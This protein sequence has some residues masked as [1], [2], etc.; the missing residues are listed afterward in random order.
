MTAFLVEDICHIIR[1]P[2]PF[3]MHHD[4]HYFQSNRIIARLQ[5]SLQDAANPQL[6]ASIASSQKVSPDIVRGINILQIRYTVNLWRGQWE[7]DQV[8]IPPSLQKQVAQQLMK[9]DFVEDQIASILYVSEYL[10]SLN[11]ITAPEVFAIFE[12]LFRSNYVTN[13]FV[14]D[15]FAS[16]VLSV[17]LQRDQTAVKTR[18]CQIWLPSPNIWQARAALV[19]FSHMSDIVIFKNEILYG[20]SLLIRRPDVPAKSAAGLALHALSK[21]DKPSVMNFLEPEETLFHFTAQPLSKATERLMDPTFVRSIKA[22]RKRV[23]KTGLYPGTPSAALP[24]PQYVMETAPAF[25]PIPT[26]M[27][28]D[29]TTQTYPDPQLHTDPTAV[30]FSLEGTFGEHATD[31]DEITAEEIVAAPHA[32]MEEMQNPDE[33]ASTTAD[34]YLKPSEE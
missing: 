14:T 19:A 28:E 13:R 33:E 7:T 34:E 16:K 11:I 1:A 12:P 17:L 26:L 32:I 2:Q 6:K 24:M 8:S 21:E 5:R 27:N 10:L 31:V 30:S 23:Q 22:V 25:I 18:L 20:C 29:V 9:Q 15:N 3:H 4:D